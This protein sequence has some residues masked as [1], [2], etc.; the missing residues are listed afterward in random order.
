MFVQDRLPLTG[1]V[2]ATVLLAAVIH[3]SE[4]MRVLLAG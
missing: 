4:R 3:V 1:W 2:E